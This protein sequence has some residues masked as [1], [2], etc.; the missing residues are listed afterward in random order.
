MYYF[1]AQ[2]VFGIIL[3]KVYFSQSKGLSRPRKT[4]RFVSR[5]VQAWWEKMWKSGSSFQGNVTIWWE[6][7]YFSIKKYIRNSGK[8][9]YLPGEKYIFPD[10]R[11][12]ACQS[13]SASR[14]QLF[15]LKRYCFFAMNGSQIAAAGFACLYLMP[16]WLADSKQ[17]KVTV[18]TGSNLD[19]SGVRIA[20]YTLTVKLE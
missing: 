14:P 10:L 16:N 1:R 19:G 9:N 17:Q 8:C 5:F 15:F 3:V 6:I 7:L 11:A 12:S 2:V 20:Y 4:V 13:Q 18:L